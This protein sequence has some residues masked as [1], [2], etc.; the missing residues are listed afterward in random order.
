MLD[1]L[2]ELEERYDELTRQLASPE[3]ASDPS[4]LASL[5]RELSRLEPVVSTLREVRRL[6]AE[7][8]ATQELATDS[9]IVSDT[10]WV[11]RQRPACPAGLRGLQ[12]FE[13]T[14][15]TGQTDQHSGTT[16]GAARN[17]IG[18]LM[19]LVSQMYDATTGRVKI[20][21][22]YDDVEKPTRGQGRVRRQNASDGP[23]DAS[24]PRRAA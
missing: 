16:G 22:F 6:E 24:T 18:E 13:L 1:R 2:S 20:K 14:L 17:P 19:K 15:E 3:H 8:A 23:G 11:S 12:G 21:G 9:V 7:Q 4:S 5:G 10:I